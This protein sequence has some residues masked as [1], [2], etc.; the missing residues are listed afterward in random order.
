MVLQV[1]RLLQNQGMALPLP[2]CLQA[3]LHQEQGQKRHQMQ[4]VKMMERH[5][6]NLRG[7]EDVEPGK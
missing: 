7:L 2:M 6:V 3:T 5:A 4:Q 1:A